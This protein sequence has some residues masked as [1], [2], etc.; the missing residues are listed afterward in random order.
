[1]AKEHPFGEYGLEVPPTHTAGGTLQ[2]PGGGSATK[3][4]RL[5]GNLGTRSRIVSHMTRNLIRLGTP[6]SEGGLAL[7]EE[8]EAGDTWYPSGQQH[9]RRIG[10][11]MGADQR[12]GAAL[13]SS[14]SPQTDWELN[15]IKAH[16]IAV[17]GTPTYENAGWSPK[18]SGGKWVDQR[19][20]KAEAVV[21]LARQGQDATHLFP[22]GRKT[23]HFLEN[24][25]N[26]ED[27]RFVTI[28]THAHNAAVASRTSSDKT[29]LSSV[30]RYGIFADSYHGAANKLGILP[31]ATQARVWT[32]W[33]RM[34]PM[35]SPHNFDSYLRQTGQYDDYYAI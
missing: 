27:P 25:D 28:D 10:A 8:I 35:S 1:M 31:S 12:S 16:D 29:G 33:K 34:N 15:L 22:Q 2:I 3:A 26:P 13:I 24:I 5:P 14:L 4:S 11:L 21:A 23:H 20:N 9:A 18:T 6:E 19:Q 7:P 30:G 17:H 32:T